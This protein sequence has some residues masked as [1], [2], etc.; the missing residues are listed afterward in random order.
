MPAAGAAV[1]AF[2]KLAVV[3]VEAAV[4]GGKVVAAVRVGR[5]AVDS[6]A[7]SAEVVSLAAEVLAEA[8]VVAADTSASIAFL[9]SP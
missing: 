6:A 2:D 4:V 1:V 3:D 7:K 9:S 5:S 8:A